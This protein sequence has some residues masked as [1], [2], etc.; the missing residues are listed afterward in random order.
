MPT[1]PGPLDREEHEQRLADI[2]AASRLG[3]HIIDRGRA[4]GCLGSGDRVVLISGTG[5][6]SS[7]Y[8]MIVV[9][10]LD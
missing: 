9:Q 8:N 7:R 6:K 2:R 4:S 1:A 5:L 10:Q 3:Q